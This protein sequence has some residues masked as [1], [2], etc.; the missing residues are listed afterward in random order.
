MSGIH[1][2]NRRQSKTL[3]LSTNVDKKSLETEF[4]IVICRPIGKWQLKTPF[5]PIFEPR[6]SIVK[7]VFDCCLS[8]VIQ[9]RHKTKFSIGTVFQIFWK[10]PICF[11]ILTF[12]ILYGC[13]KSFILENIALPIIT[14][15]YDLYISH[16]N[17]II[18]SQ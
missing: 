4:S 16:E 5:L 18:W 15:L 9:W 3:I 13:F 7:S 1:T 11:K 6:S 17:E 8:C 12:I 14:H 2:P 10:H